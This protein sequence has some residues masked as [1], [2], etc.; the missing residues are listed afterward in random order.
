M[1]MVLAP[2]A[3]SKR[4]ADSAIH[5]KSDISLFGTRLETIQAP[6]SSHYNTAP[7]PRHLA[8]SEFFLFFLPDRPDFLVRLAGI[9]LR[10]STFRAVQALVLRSRS[11][12]RRVPLMRCLSSHFGGHRSGERDSHKT[13]EFSALKS[14]VKKRMRIQD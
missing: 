1:R 6:D 12:P 3:P 9:M 4:R 5:P 10:Q 13:C 14:C 11:L 2:A 7:P 8:P